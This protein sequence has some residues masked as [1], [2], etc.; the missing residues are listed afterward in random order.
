MKNDERRRHSD[1]ASRMGE[2]GMPAEL[3]EQGR[4]LL[5]IAINGVQ[6]ERLKHGETGSLYCDSGPFCPECGALKGE[7]HILGCNAERCANCQGEFITCGCKVEGLG[8]EWAGF[9][10]ERELP[11]D[12]QQNMAKKLVSFLGSPGWLL[13][14]DS[15]DDIPDSALLW[16]FR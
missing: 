16:G 2:A 3:F 4:K 7:V 11:R 10:H 12:E 8:P 6:L 1:A 9:M 13:L 14:G 5:R 15:G